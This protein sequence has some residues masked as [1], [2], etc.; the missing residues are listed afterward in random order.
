MAVAR[1]NATS[2]APPP[3]VLG[4]SLDL[5]DGEIVEARVLADLGKGEVLLA[6]RG[7]AV[8]AHSDQP[9]PLQARLMLEVA[10]G[11]A[12]VR[13]KRVDGRDLALVSAPAHRQAALGLAGPAAQHLLAAFEQAGA[14]LDPERLAAALATLEGLPAEEVPKHA[15][16]QALLAAARL[17][18]TP[19]L[20][21]LALVA[22]SEQL[23]DLARSLAALADPKA[24]TDPA[25][26]TDDPA[27]AA[28]RLPTSTTVPA[29]AAHLPAQ[30]A[31]PTLSSVHT[32]TFTVIGGQIAAVSARNA[33]AIIPIAAGPTEADSTSPPIPAQ[34][35]RATPSGAAL[36][37][38]SPPVTAPGAAAD[39]PRSPAH[40]DTARAGL[41]PPTNHERLSPAAIPV[42]S[43]PQPLGTTTAPAGVS[44]L[45]I[46]NSAAEPAPSR[47]NPTRPANVNVVASPAAAVIPPGR[48]PAADPPAS[49]ALARPGLGAPTAPHLIT[50][51]IASAH[52]ATYTMPVP[53]IKSPGATATPPAGQT[54]ITALED[55]PSARAGVPPMA[56][57]SATSV[58][59][60]PADAATRLPAALGQAAPPAMVPPAPQTSTTSNSA[61]TVP[62]ATLPFMPP[63]SATGSSPPDL[64]QIASAPPSAI[65][66]AS[67]T[68]PPSMLPNATI[69]RTSSALPATLAYLA[70]TLPD[71]TQD[72]ALAVHRALL[73]VGVRPTGF[74]ALGILPDPASTDGSRSLALQ[75]L[76]PA[77]TELAAL[78]K[79]LPAAIAHSADAQVT[80]PS[81]PG[82]A[83][84]LRTE[85]P[86]AAVDA[87]RET[88]AGHLFKPKELADYDQVV[89]LPL[90]SQGLPTPA[91]LAVTSR[92]T[93]N[94]QAATWVR[95]DTELSRLGPVS[96]RLSGMTGGP[97]AITMVATSQGTPRLAAMLPDLMT[98]L[99]SLGLQAAVRVAEADDTR[100]AQTP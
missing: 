85:P 39:A 83:L 8:V 86:A 97:I 80:V 57:P 15:L 76:S 18:A 31:A 49:A 51:F 58:S 10:D 81:D 1:T 17:P 100:Q 16:A 20:L 78:H 28:P 29:P 32:P 47:S 44:R 41:A 62:A 84:P 99:E 12:T 52:T 92:A 40:T 93:A 66:T 63:A 73:L 50:S 37:A 38:S 9:L 33:E 34:T 46:S 70:A 69:H 55:A 61:S 24:L 25:A 88:L 27:A 91:R 36:S 82:Q 71:A 56:A 54:R 94:G 67:P 43:S 64:R 19:A 89:P 77:D 4:G 48:S 13:L 90:T 11:G 95:V 14:P 74:T 3:P 68:S 21:S 22:A 98:A 23:P 45:P 42:S 30:A 72:G 5:V 79:A 53:V 65:A 60:S 2:S 59:S 6:V 96:V 7:R 35:T 26:A 75:P 87:A